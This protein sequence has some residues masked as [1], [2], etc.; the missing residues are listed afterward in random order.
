MIEL[1]LPTGYFCVLHAITH[2]F[3]VV[4]DSNNQ[5]LQIMR[6]RYGV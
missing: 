2:A 3:L 5:S 4:G 6:F 1:T